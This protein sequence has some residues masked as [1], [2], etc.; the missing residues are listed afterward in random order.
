M[1]SIKFIRFANFYF[2]IKY[3]LLTVWIILGLMLINSWNIYYCQTLS[4]F[5]TIPDYKIRLK[6]SSKM[7][8]T[9][10]NLSNSQDLSVQEILLRMTEFLK[11]NLK[12]ISVHTIKNFSKKS[13]PFKIVSCSI[14]TFITIKCKIKRSK[15]EKNSVK[16]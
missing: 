7:W 8:K 4:I 9:C 1:L 14:N 16:T 12:E 10:S 3:C 5:S 15:K 13:P 11:E 6:I 2:N